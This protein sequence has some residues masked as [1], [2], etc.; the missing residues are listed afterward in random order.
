[1]NALNDALNAKLGLKEL[2]TV[3]DLLDAKLDALFVKLGFEE[4]GTVG[5]PK[6]ERQA[7][8]LVSAPPVAA[9]LDMAVQV[10]GR[11]RNAAQ[12]VVRK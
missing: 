4:N 1:M 11:I 5:L 7:E 3:A 8:N 12:D 9:L 2:Q 6:I 10:V